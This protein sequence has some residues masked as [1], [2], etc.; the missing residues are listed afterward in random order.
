LSWPRT[1]RA[2]Y[3]Q[4]VEIAAGVVAAEL[5]AYAV[6][7]AGEESHINEVLTGLATLFTLLTVFIASRVLRESRAAQRDAALDRRVRALLRAADL[8][9]EASAAVE[10]RNDP[11]FRHA[12]VRLRI[13]I[14]ALGDDAPPAIGRLTVTAPKSLDV[15]SALMEA[16]EGIA[17]AMEEAR[18][19]DARG[20]ET[21][22][23]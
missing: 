2:S 15:H 19:P 3:L 17:A 1:R 14:G 7:E 18:S 20:R 23:P 8:V 10:A 13:T 22:R 4:A 12:I 11:L 6:I 16:L 5:V 9:D 21:S